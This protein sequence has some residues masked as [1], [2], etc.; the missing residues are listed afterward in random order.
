MDLKPFFF[1]ALLVTPSVAQEIELSNTPFQETRYPTSKVSGDVIMGVMLTA[2]RTVDGDFSVITGVP[3]EWRESDADTKICVRLV[4]KD[5]LYDAE[6]TYDVPA[7]YT[8]KVALFPYEG[9]EQEFLKQRNLVARVSL[10][11]CGVRTDVVVAANRIASD[12]GSSDTLHIFLNS[13]GDPTAV[14]VGTGIDFF[15]PCRDI[16]QGDGLKY[17]TVCDIPLKH[18]DTNEGNR[19]TFII[20]RNTTEERFSLNVLPYFAHVR[21]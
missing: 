9:R 18:L 14:A 4:S 17:T 2:D 7:S 20:S 11:S 3:D 21:Q 15:K 10:G 5:G 6:N 13:A 12:Q 19:L 1:S 16:S 8:K